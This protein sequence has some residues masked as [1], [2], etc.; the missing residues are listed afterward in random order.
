M[1]T[2]QSRGTTNVAPRPQIL[3]LRSSEDNPYQIQDDAEHNNLFVGGKLLIKSA[4]AGIWSMKDSPSKLCPLP[5]IGHFTAVDE[6]NNFVY[7]GYGVSSKSELLNDVWKFNLSTFEWT[8]LN[9]TGNIATPRCGSR[10]VYSDGKI[11][12]FGGFK[13]PEYYG[14]LH[15]ID[16]NTNEVLFPVCRGF[17]PPPR[18]TPIMGIYN[19]KLYV[20][21]GFYHT[22]D[23]NINI[24]DLLSFTWTTIDSGISAR[25]AAPSVIYQSQLFSYGGS[26][27][28]GVFSLDLETNKCDMLETRGPCPPITTMNAA[29]VLVENYVFFI[30][31]KR[32]AQYTFVYTYDIKK[33]WWFVFHIEPDGITLSFQDGYLNSHGLFMVPC[34]HSF[35]ACYIKQKREIL[36]FLGSQMIDP[37]PLF[38]IDI[39]DAMSFIH[40]R[41]DMYDALMAFVTPKKSPELNDCDQY[42]DA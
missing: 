40:L 15:V 24:L 42:N 10:A 7:I 5:R 31:G 33:Q 34:Y 11:Y 25:T 39:G 38:S 35:S 12:I 2:N 6:D 22:C 3:G 9:L 41:D 13:D 8:Q 18:S 1:G 26:Q 20:L 32:G 37:P 16:T 29:M 23:R 4:F 19:N 36:M 28:G 27:I 14:D 30:G 21:S 17:I